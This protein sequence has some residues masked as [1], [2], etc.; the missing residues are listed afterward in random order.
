MPVFLLDVLNLVVIHV[1]AQTADASTAIV[2][3]L[4]LQLRQPI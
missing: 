1:R 2:Y 3:P 4:V